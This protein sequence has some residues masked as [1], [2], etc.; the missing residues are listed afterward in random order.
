MDGRLEIF[1]DF[2]GFVWF[3]VDL[4]TKACMCYVVN[5]EFGR[6]KDFEIPRQME[7]CK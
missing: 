5:T 3:L 7:Q 2:L 6:A 4:T 1:V